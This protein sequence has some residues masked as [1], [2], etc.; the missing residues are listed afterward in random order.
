MSQAPF[1][2]LWPTLWWIA[3]SVYL[4]SYVAFSDLI[5]SLS[6]LSTHI[7]MVVPSDFF[8]KDSSVLFVC[9]H[10]DCSHDF[11]HL[12]SFPR[13]WAFRKV[14]LVQLQ[15]FVIIKLF[16]L[17][18]HQLVKVG[19]SYVWPFCSHF[20]EHLYKHFCTY[21]N[22]HSWWDVLWSP[23][24]AGSNVYFFKFICNLILFCYRKL[25]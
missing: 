22:F 19:L 14:S 9:L 23:G 25:F 1:V 18:I 16:F 5:L 3:C 8:L 21:L 15:F 7:H 4:V 11:I 2:S 12:N 24:F 6:M 10:R 17:F 13:T 20:I